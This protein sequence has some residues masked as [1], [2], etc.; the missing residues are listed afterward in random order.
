MH[1]G[2]GIVLYYPYVVV[3]LISSRHAKVIT[4]EALMTTSVIVRRIG[5]ENRVVIVAFLLSE[6]S[7]PGFL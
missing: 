1:D 6:L 7:T 5:A 3:E 4:L 2:H